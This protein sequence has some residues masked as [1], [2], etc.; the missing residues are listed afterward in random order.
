MFPLRHGEA[1]AEESP[2]ARLLTLKDAGHGVDRADWRRS[3]P[4]SSNTPRRNECRL[5]PPAPR[6]RLVR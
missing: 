1:L 4:R 3:S 5:E 2:G 6:G